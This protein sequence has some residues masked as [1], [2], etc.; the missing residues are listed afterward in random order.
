MIANPAATTLDEVALETNTA[1]GIFVQPQHLLGGGP[2]TP[3]T[4]VYTLAVAPINAS[5]T[6]VEGSSA[7]FTWDINSN[8]AHTIADIQRSTDDATFM[9]ISTQT[10]TSYDDEGLG[11]RGP[12][13]G[14][15]HPEQSVPTGEAKDSS[16]SLQHSQLMSKC[17]DLGCEVTSRFDEGED[18]REDGL[19]GIP[20]GAV[21]EFS[22]T[23]RIDTPKEVD[24]YRHGG[25]LQYVLR[26][27]LGTCGVPVG[28]PQT[29]G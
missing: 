19:R 14:Q 23:I 24:Y 3:T 9:T 4:T 8:P 10:A 27:L 20:E 1:Y 13:L 26:Q 22:A 11:P 5:T 18:R 15:E 29:K 16:S 7:T 21:R 17:D 25:I 28:S 2:L 6:Q 12:S